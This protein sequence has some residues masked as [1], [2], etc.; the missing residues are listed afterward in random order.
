MG[1]GDIMYQSILG[2]IL[3][4]AMVCYLENYGAEKF[5]E[6]FLGEF[7]T[8]EVSL[9]SFELTNVILLREGLGVSNGAR[10]FMDFFV[11]F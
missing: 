4:E 11:C 1:G 3:P 2:Q 8:P 6:I 7:D 10:H 5:A 9:E